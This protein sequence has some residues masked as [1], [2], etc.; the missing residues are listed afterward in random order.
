MGGVSAHPAEA[1]QPNSEPVAQ[2]VSAVKNDLKSRF[3]RT[4]FISIYY[5]Y[6]VNDG[7]SL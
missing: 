1:A 2:T 3:T 6:I 5:G 4:L 7:A